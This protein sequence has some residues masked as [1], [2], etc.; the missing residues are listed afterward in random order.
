MVKTPKNKDVVMHAQ[1]ETILFHYWWCPTRAKG[2]AMTTQPYVKFVFNI[3]LD[4]H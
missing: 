4:D 2:I 3:V 1:L